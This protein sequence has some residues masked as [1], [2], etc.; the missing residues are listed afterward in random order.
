MRTNKLLFS[1]FAASALCGAA[2]AA[3]MPGSHDPQGMKRFQGSQIIQFINRSFDHYTFATGPGTPGGGF[4]KS[5]ALEGQVTRVIYHIPSGHTPLE[6][7]RNYEH[8]L[9]DAGFKTAY[10]IQPCATLEWGGYFVGKFYGQG[11]PTDN[12]PFTVV[13][14]GCYIYAKGTAGGKQAGVA[15]LVGE[16]SSDVNFHPIGGAPNQVIPIKNGDVLVEVDEVIAVPVA[17][18]MT[19]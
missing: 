12:N 2:A 7:L 10:E 5:E 16:L 17:N 19:K 3:D 11:G 15:V 13:S 8:M 18:G 6:L 4:T 9:A 1:L 14:N